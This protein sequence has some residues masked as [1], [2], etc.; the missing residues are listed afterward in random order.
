MTTTQV[1]ETSVTVNNSPIQD[2]AHPADD[3]AQPTSTY[4]LIVS[5]DVWVAK[6]PP[7][8]PPLLFSVQQ[9][10]H[11]RPKQALLELYGRFLKQR[12]VSVALKKA[13]S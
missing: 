7:P 8:P 1:V 4:C 5:N 9:I 2:Y 12:P 6:V 13:N 3:Y 11:Y 10:S